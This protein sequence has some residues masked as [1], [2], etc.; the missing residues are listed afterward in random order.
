[1]ERRHESS[2]PSPDH[3][4]CHGLTNL[5]QLAA[6]STLAYISDLE[7]GLRVIKDGQAI[8]LPLSSFWPRYGSNGTISEKGFAHYGPF[9]KLWGKSDIS[10]GSCHYQI[11]QSEYQRI[12]VELY[13]RTATVTRQ[14]I[15]LMLASYPML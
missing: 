12:T 7:N 5:Y 15:E 10:L 1:M 8:T 9:G 2:N 14:G 3:Q 6:E 11:P 4:N 13:S